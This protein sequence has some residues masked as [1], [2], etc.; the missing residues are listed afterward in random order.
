M[1]KTFETIKLLRQPGF[2]F[3]GPQF[4]HDDT[5][6][7][8]EDSRLIYKTLSGRRPKTED[9]DVIRESVKATVMRLFELCIQHEYWFYD[10]PGA[11]NN[12]IHGALNR[13]LEQWEIPSLLTP[14][15]VR[16]VV[17]S[18]IEARTLCTSNERSELSDRV[19]EFMDIWRTAVKREEEAAQ[20]T[21]PKSKAD[22]WL[23]ADFAP[24]E[25]GMLYSQ[26]IFNEIRDISASNPTMPEL[27]DQETDPIQIQKF[28]CTLA[29][30][31]FSDTRRF[32]LYL[33]PI[34]YL[35]RSEKRAAHDSDYSTIHG[36]VKYA[37]EMLVHHNR[38]MA[39]G[40][41]TFPNRTTPKALLIHKA[42]QLWGSP[43]GIR[44][45]C[46]DPQEE[47]GEYID[48][49]MEKIKDAFGNEI[50]EAYWGGWTEEEAIKYDG[51]YM[52]WVCAFIQRVV[53][54]DEPVP[55]YL[56]DDYGYQSISLYF[57]F[58]W[59]EGYV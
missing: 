34:G 29:L 6:D 44:F 2:H 36:F 54:N 15:L 14:M 59:G 13:V 7:S 52:E 22:P 8:L 40:L 20:A 51:R 35:N 50:T 11:N 3:V 25:R 23:S 1:G 42:L 56:V 12:A 21:Q 30:S 37:R 33:H 24:C 43:P 53:T 58:R 55:D 16:L 4:R 47:V 17:G 48:T 32:A 45:L 41:V 46:L 19:D 5:R 38:N 39:I 26:R 57:R 31:F 9:R 28:L 27:S 18:Y 49:I 10:Y